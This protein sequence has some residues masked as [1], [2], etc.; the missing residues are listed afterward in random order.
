M[1]YVA[2]FMTQQ[3]ARA[4]YSRLIAHLFNDD[5]STFFL[6]TYIYIYV[7]VCVCVCVCE[8]MCT[9]YTWQQAMTHTILFIQI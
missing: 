9:Y 2:L 1:R 6:F 5:A 8:H 7:C 3:T 4:I